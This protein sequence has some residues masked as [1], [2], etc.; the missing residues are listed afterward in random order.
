MEWCHIQ[1]VFL[2]HAGINDKV[3]IWFQNL[4]HNKIIPFLQSIPAICVTIPMLHLHQGLFQT[5]FPRI[6]YSILINPKLHPVA[7]F[8]RKLSSTEQNNDVGNLELLAIRLTLEDWRHRLKSAAHPENPSPLCYS[9]ACLDSS[10]PC[11][12]GMPAPQSPPQWITS[13][14]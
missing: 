2:L 14:K 13:S 8:S 12:P 4:N 5:P 1:G 6:H 7:F 3:M 10:L 11:S 9:S